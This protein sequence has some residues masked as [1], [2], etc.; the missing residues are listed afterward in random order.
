MDTQAPVPAALRPYVA[1]LSAYDVVGPPGIHRGLPGTS[2][3]FVLPIGA[4]LDVAWSGDPGS[5]GAVWSSVAGLHAAPAEIRHDGHQEGFFLALT[6]AGARAL[7]GLPAAAI[8]GELLTLDDLVPALRH[9]P[10]QLHQSLTWTDRAATLHRALTTAL[11]AGGAPEAR[12]EVGRALARLARGAAVAD[13]AEEVGYSR[14]HLR[15]LVVAETGLSPKEYQRVARFE[16]SRDQVLAAARRGGTLAEVAANC[17]Y[18]DQSHLAREW[19]E[20]A[21]CAPT[22]WLREEF[23]D[24]QAGGVPVG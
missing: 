23:P 17:G 3:T 8:A 24:V 1:W 6:T 5:R 20:L 12:A 2:L 11:A 14:R 7:L 18:A 4:P 9:L 21:G 22:T 13:V 16:T 15:N 19:R 10:E